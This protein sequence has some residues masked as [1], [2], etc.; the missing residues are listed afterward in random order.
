MRLV[1][2]RAGE[3]APRPGALVDDAVVPLAAASIEELLS[4]GRPALEQA[5][6]EASRPG[7][8]ALP[9][10]DVALTVP[11]ATAV[12]VAP[13]PT[14]AADH[15]H[16][17]HAHRE[18]Y[19][20]SAHTVVAGHGELPYREALGT[21]SYRAQ[22]GLVLA[23][24]ARRLDTGAVLDQVLGV[25]LA[26]ELYSVDLL[27]VGWEGTMW[28]VRY[29]EGASFDGACPIG[30]MFVTLDELRLG[31]LQLEDKSGARRLNEDAVAEFVAY[32]SGWMQLGP[33][34]LVLAG[35][36]HGPRLI[37]EHDDPVVAWPDGEPRLT[38]G[39]RVSARG[40]GLGE[41]DVVVGA[42]RASKRR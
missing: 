6:A 3:A 27:R 4:R 24:G 7:V 23:P 12:V 19:L 33:T 29:G 31:E 36:G 25:V 14:V 37:V 30:S 35:S 5:H 13:G 21:L 18:F 10:T 34:T 16:R 22:V 40:N 1:M 2:F 39:D 8:A 32:V 28:H 26:A 11:L 38:T 17:L 41:I 20:K 9:L 15:A 42:A